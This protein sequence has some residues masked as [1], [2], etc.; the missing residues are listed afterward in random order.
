MD[1]SF[2]KDV[3][4][5]T[6]NSKKVK[7]D[8][9]F[10]AIRGTSVDG[11]NFI[12]EAVKK[13]ATHIVLEDKEK[14]KEIENKYPYIKTF[15]TDNARKTQAII[16]RELFGNP[17]KNLTVIGIT[18]TNGKT[19]TS[20][21]IYQYL[22]LFNKDAGII[23]TIE[24]RFKDR[25]FSSGRTTP[26]SIE[27][28]SLL[29]KMKDL[30]AEY[31]VSEVSSH[32]VDQYRIYGTRFSAAVFTNLTQDHLDYHKTMENYFL[33]KK[34][35][36]EYAL[37]KNSDTICIINTDD[38]YG[39]RIFN[40]LKVK[41]KNIF[42]YGRKQSNYI[43]ENVD[44]SLKGTN[45]NLI[46]KGK[47][48]LVE[49]KLLGEFNVYNL[50]A[51]ISTLHS[52]GFP[53]KELVEKA[54]NLNPIKGRFETVYSGDFLVV[55]DYAHTPDALEN[56]L[57]SL[58]KIKHNRLIV[59]FGAGGDRDKTKRPL[60]GKVAE[61]FADIVILT[62]DNPR[63]EDPLQIIEDIKKGMEKSPVVIE[64]REQAIK[65][66]IEIANKGDI[67]LVAGKGHETYQIIG[68]KILPFDD[69]KVIKKYV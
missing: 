21:L 39:K 29:G 6:N 59:V 35:F 18:G 49:T 25:V 65:K 53:L 4:G 37:E 15:L 22:N 20:N 66:A 67:V 60:M 54:S 55:N 45:F 34:R 61:K 2:L 28:F 52:L 8:Y 42:S 51:A 11:H 64:D 68:D 3:K 13:G 41:G 62:S 14:K 69:T 56:I 36:F 10:V 48:Y 47:R 57:R 1:L 23:G 50:T 32:A 7:E 43:I 58:K 24:Y 44:I 27:W 19:T 12:D 31:V 30:G 63:T 46:F 5:I 17:D 26:D 16:S 38:N 33:A 9:L 40:E